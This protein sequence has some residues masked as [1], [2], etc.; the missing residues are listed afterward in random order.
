M[1]LVHADFVYETSVITGTGSYNLDGAAAGHQG[2]VAGIGNGNTCWYC[3]EDEVNWEV[4]VGTITD[5]TPDTLARTSILASS[6]AGAS[7]AWSA[8]TKHLRCTLP[9]AITLNKGLATWKNYTANATWSKPAGLKY[10]MVECVGG[11][12]GGGA[13]NGTT[14]GSSGGGAGG[15]AR[16]YIAA[17]SLGATEAV[18][19][20]SGGAP[21]TAGGAGTNGGATTFGTH[22]TACGGTVGFCSAG[23]LGNQGGSGGAATSGTI[24][25][26]GGF[27]GTGFGF[28]VTASVAGAIAGGGAG[29]RSFF[30][31]G[32]GRRLKSTTG[33][34]LCGRPGK[35]WGSG[36]GGGVAFSA[37]PAGG[38]AGK[39]GACIVWEFY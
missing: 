6:N 30:G 29:G 36:G 18:V 3:A 4:G 9:G 28:G 27:G 35:A 1:A 2:F 24:N 16:K 20:G 12:G 19:V 10:A 22:M 21:T 25:V 37:S 8:G 38:G 32:G 39:G 15:Y 34:S 11:G 33:A 31:G 17:A 13:T 23:I 14:S 7:V 26:Q 5:G